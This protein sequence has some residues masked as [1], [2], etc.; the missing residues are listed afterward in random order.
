MKTV[1]VTGF[2]LTILLKSYLSDRQQ[3][4]VYNG[5]QTTFL[6][7]DCSVP[8][9]SVLGPLEVVAYTE[10]SSDVV[11]KHDINQ[12]TLHMP[13]IINC[14]PAVFHETSLVLVSVYPNALPTS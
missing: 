14:T 1:V 13:M 2:L 5:Q 12:H 8:Q 11:A 7:L 9:G 10:D 3:S 6:P 4:F